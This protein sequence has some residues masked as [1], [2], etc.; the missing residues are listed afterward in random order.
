MRCDCHLKGDRVVIPLRNYGSS[1]TYSSIKHVPEAFH[2]SLRLHF[3]TMQVALL[4]VEWVLRGD[5]W[6]RHRG[7]DVESSGARACRQGYLL[8]WDALSRL[9]QVESDSLAPTVFPGG[10]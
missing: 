2:V 1:G 8:A 5:V 9:V 7:R 4:V 10:N 3:M 6:R